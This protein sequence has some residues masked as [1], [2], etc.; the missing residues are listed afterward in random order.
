M[1]ASQRCKIDT[2]S[3]YYKNLG[4]KESREIEDKYINQNLTGAEKY[5]ANFANE[6]ENQILKIN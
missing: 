4:E 5:V 3:S 6:T 1:I 2:E